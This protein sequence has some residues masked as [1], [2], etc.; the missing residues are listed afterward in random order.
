MQQL[1]TYSTFPEE[2]LFDVLVENDIS[3]VFD[4][5]TGR[6]RPPQRVHDGRVVLEVVR[7]DHTLDVLG[8]LLLYHRQTG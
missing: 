7:S 1:R 5:L 2:R 3:V 6:V 4:E 8:R